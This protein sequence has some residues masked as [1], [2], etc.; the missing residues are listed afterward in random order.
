MAVLYW[1]NQNNTAILICCSNRIIE[2][3]NNHCDLQSNY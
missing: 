2:K 3:L 1:L